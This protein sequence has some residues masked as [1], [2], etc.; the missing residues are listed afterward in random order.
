MVKR[1]MVITL[2]LGAVLI[3]CTS[4]K[5]IVGPILTDA[6][7]FNFE[8]GL[9]DGW[10][11]STYFDSKA[12][13]TADATKVKAAVGDYSLK[14]NVNLISGSDSMSKGEVSVDMR[15][16]KPFGISQVPLDLNT[17]TITVW[18]YIPGTLKGDPPTAPNGLQIFLKDSNYFN[19]YSSFIKVVDTIA[20]NTWYKVQ[21]QVSTTAGSYGFMD[22][23]FNPNKIIILGVKIGTAGAA[24]NVNQ[25]DGC[26]IDSITWE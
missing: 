3:H 14:L 22:E 1:V 25:D 5:D 20:T 23:N 7:R 11:P 26:Y 10:M 4:E 24:T 8:S 6:S 16:Y 12:I 18:T 21:V 13:K 15:K 17:K 2:I 9:T 19:W